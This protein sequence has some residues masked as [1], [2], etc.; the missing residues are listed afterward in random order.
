VVF[1]LACA[2]RTSEDDMGNFEAVCADDSYSQPYGGWR[3]YSREKN[4]VN[5]ITSLNDL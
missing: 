4:C 5:D 2:V 3:I 1:Y